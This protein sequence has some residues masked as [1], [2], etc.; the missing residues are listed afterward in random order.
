MLCRL[1]N[2]NQDYK[3]SIEITLHMKNRDG[4]PNG[5]IIT[6]EFEKGSSLAGW[7]CSQPGRNLDKEVDNA[8]R[9]DSV[10]QNKRKKSPFKKDSDKTPPTKK[11]GAY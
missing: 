5:H 1:L 3:M 8:Q 2:F 6:K 11:K 7:Y 9:H 4:S 10:F